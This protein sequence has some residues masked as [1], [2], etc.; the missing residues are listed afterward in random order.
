MAGGAR[1]RAPGNTGESGTGRLATSGAERPT[2]IGQAG[3]G[4]IGGTSGGLWISRPQ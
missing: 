2:A 1:E 3:S 4:S